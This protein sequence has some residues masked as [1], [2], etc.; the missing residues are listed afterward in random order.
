MEGFYNKSGPTH[1]PSHIV[2]QIR[3]G[4]MGMEGEERLKKEVEYSHKYQINGLIVHEIG[5]SGETGKKPKLFTI[6]Y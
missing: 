6:K 1:I 4:V 2:E 3:C 5:L